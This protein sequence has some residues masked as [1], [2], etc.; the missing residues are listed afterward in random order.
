MPNVSTLIDNFNDNSIGP[1]WGDS[2]GGVSETGG[3]A[4]VPCI[5]SY[6]AYQSGAAWT[7]TGGSAYVKLVTKPALSTGT[8]VTTAFV[9]ESA[10]EGKAIQW[11]YVAAATPKLRAQ[12]ITSYDDPASVELTYDATNHAWLR[13]R[14]AS[15]TVYWDTS[16]DGTTWTNRRTLATPS[17]VGTDAEQCNI[18]LI[19]YRNAGTVDFAE[20]D[21]FNTT[22]NGAVLVGAAT[23]TSETS[24]TAAATR[25]IA[26]TA[27]LTAEAALTTDTALTVSGAAAFSATASLTAQAAGP[28][29]DTLVG[30]AHAGWEVS[31]PWR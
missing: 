2:Y 15:G 18:Q 4:R 27:G 7:L 22:G 19:A 10:T 16:A 29:L 8:T 13:I 28:I 20:Y 14:E 25:V 3:R 9:V 6:A 24:L 26:V 30:S 12:S 11:V 5:S 21:N 31:G 1:N 23:L 17:W